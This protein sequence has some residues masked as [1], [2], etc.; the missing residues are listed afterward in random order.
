M[1]DIFGSPTNDILYG[2]NDGERIFAGLGND[3]LSGGYGNDSLFGDLNSETVFVADYPSMFADQGN[4]F[5]IGGAGDDT[6]LD[7]FGNNRLYGGS[8]NDTI[9][10]TGTLKG[11][12]GNDSLDSS[13]QGHTEETGGRGADHFG[14]VLTALSDQLTPG[15]TSPT[16]IIHDFHPGEGDKIFLLGQNDSGNLFTTRDV[17]NAFDDNHDN[18][19]TT[20]DTWVNPTADGTGIQLLW[21]NS[22]ETIEHTHSIQADWIV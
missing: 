19:L 21:W 4:D 9:L 5:L 14:A 10:G 17:F 7:E 8:G 18:Q 12:D 22:S 2:T 3:R 13:Y 16:T 20:A 15:D 6:L 1:S 11:G